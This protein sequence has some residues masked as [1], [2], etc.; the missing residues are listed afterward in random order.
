MNIIK[1]EEKL[2]SGVN[3]IFYDKDI[4][5]L[6]SRLNEEY[7]CIYFNE[8]VPVKM[9]LIELIEK[10]SSNKRLSLRRLTIS[11]LREIFVRELAYERIIIMFNHFERLTKRS[12]EFYQF[13]NSLPNVTF[14]C[15]FKRNFKPEVYPFFKTFF[16]VNQDEYHQKN[17]KDE[18]NVTYTI[19][20]ILSC[21]CFVVYLKTA[22]SLFMAFLLIGAAWFAL[23]IFRT[24]IYVGGRV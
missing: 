4:Y 23:I 8:P 14:I 15:S 11:E 18:I 22:T 1:I 9:R 17:S 20:L 6:F 12:V 16:L 21:L 19:Y 5:P 24:F 13:I 10:V 3:I 7:R 2:D